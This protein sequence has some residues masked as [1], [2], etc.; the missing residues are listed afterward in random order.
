MLRHISRVYHPSRV[1]LEGQ[2]KQLWLVFNNFPGGGSAGTEA[3]SPVPLAAL[4]SAASGNGGADCES[5][6]QS[7]LTWCNS[8]GCVW[9]RGAAG[10]EDSLT[11]ELSRALSISQ[12]G[13]CLH[14]PV[15]QTAKI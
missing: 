6:G 4:S 5:S 14:L 3:R 11:F 12:I 9:R 10:R 1:T 8:R 2:S 15:E 7:E 13:V